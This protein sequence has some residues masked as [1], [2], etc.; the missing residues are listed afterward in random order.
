MCVLELTLSWP[1]RFFG[2]CHITLSHAEKRMAVCLVVATALR[3]PP[4]FTRFVLSFKSSPTAIGDV[5][6]DLLEDSCVKRSWGYKA[7]RRHLTVDHNACDGALDALEA[8]QDLFTATQPPKSR[9][10]RQT[11][12]QTGEAGSR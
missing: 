12:A 1:G 3:M 11:V 7:L 6:R 5:A 10:V 2:R 8:A 4:S 9:S